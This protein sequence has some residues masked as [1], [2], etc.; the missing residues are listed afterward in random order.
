MLNLEGG[1]ISQ[2]GATWNVTNSNRDTVYHAMN[3]W[4]LALFADMPVNKAKGTAISAYLGYFHT[5][6]GPNYLRFNGIM[7]P[8]NGTTQSLAGASGIQGNAF[9]MFGTGSVIYTQF[10]YL[11]ASDLFGKNGTLMPYASAQLADYQRL[12][13]MAGI[14]N[15]GVNWLL[16]GH[17]SKLSLDFQN[18][19]IYQNAS[20]GRLNSNGR[21]GS[22]TLQYQVFI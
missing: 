10:G 18:R 5:D 14:Y 15:I 11:C 16:K 17:N 12:T 22:L 6:Y 20:D 19:P 1:F 8:A 2:K 13:K 3:L 7:N 4:S 9:P 21:R